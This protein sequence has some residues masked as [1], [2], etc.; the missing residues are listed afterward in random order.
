MI[1]SRLIVRTPSLFVAKYL[2]MKDKDV[3]PVELAERFLLW[4]DHIGSAPGTC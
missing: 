3:G 2:S 4:L 1:S